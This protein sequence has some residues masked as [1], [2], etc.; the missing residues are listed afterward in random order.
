MKREKEVADGALAQ[1]KAEMSSLKTSVGTMKD[2][3]EELASESAKLQD[4]KRKLME[5][6]A[7]AQR[8]AAEAAKKLMHLRASGG[9]GGGDSGFTADQLE[10]QVAVLKSRLTCPVCNH[11]DKQCILL[12]CRHMFCK[13]CVEE[14][15]KVGDRV[16]T[17]YC[18]N[19]TFQFT[20]PLFYFDFYSCRIEVE[21]APLVVS[22][23]TTRT[24]M[25]FGWGDR[26]LSIIATHQFNRLSIANNFRNTAVQKEW[27]FLSLVLY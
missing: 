17:C 16:V 9:G 5:S 21:S 26:S 3:S 4:E 15:V 24:F 20:Y 8:E 14:N 27:P 10:T 13:P 22:D 23:L 12:R 18:R 25:I 1:T 6:L 2:R 7:V 19:A 11:R